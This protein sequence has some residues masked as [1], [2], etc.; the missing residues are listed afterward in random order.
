MSNLTATFT[1]PT[2]VANRFVE[3]GRDCKFPDG[4]SFHDLR[5]FFAST[6][7]F[8]GASV[9]MVAQY[10]GHASGAVTLDV[11]AHLRPGD[12]DRARDAVDKVLVRDQSGTGNRAGSAS[13]SE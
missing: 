3:L 9:P 11:Y 6:L 12:D 13:V 7:V 1:S 10:L 8:A 4:V 2:A 5:R